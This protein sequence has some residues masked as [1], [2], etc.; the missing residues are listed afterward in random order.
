MSLPE[1]DRQLSRIIVVGVTVVILFFGV[2][3]G[4]AT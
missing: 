4:W 1:N 2:L 3:G